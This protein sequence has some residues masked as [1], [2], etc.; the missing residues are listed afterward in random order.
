MR[1][2]PACLL[3]ALSLAAGCATAAPPP[4]HTAPFPKRIALLPMGNMSLDVTAPDLMRNLVDSDLSAGDLDL[5]PLRE[6]D[7]KLRTIGITEGGQLGS[8]APQKLGA[9]LGA[10]GLLYGDIEEFKGVNVGVYVNRI[11]DVKLW[12]VDA[13]TGTKLWESSRRKAHTEARLNAQAVRE[14]V[15]SDILSSPFRAAAEEVAL[16]LVRDLGKARKSW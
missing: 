4:R 9:L 11:V 13:Q 1:K 10:D 7:E 12:L 3:A 14:A 15:A 16:L 6:V 8:A 2:S 5:V